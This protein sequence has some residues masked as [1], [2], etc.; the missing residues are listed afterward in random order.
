MYW[1]Y[2]ALNRFVEEKTGVINGTR[3]EILLELQGKNFNVISLHP[4]ILEEIRLFISSRK[5]NAKQMSILFRD[6]A[7]MLETGLTLTH[8]FNTLREQTLDSHLASLYVDMGKK[9]G[10]GE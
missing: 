7:N 4:D 3:K 9:L 1:R 2:V 10:Q 6:F 5:F 8:I